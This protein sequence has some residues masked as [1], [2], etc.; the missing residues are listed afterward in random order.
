MGVRKESDRREKLV[1]YS[2]YKTFR[3]CPLS[4]STEVSSLQWKRFDHDPS[5]SPGPYEWIVNVREDVE[6]VG[7]R[8]E[9]RRKEDGRQEEEG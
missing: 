1:D 5:K 9:N 6:R 7:V 3:Q 2:R 4:G 8:R